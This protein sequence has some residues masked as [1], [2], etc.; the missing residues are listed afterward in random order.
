MDSLFHCPIEEKAET[1]LLELCCMKVD[2][3]VD[4]NNSG[5]DESWDLVTIIYCMIKAYQLKVNY[6]S[7]KFISTLQ[8][9][10]AQ[11]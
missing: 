6:L 3:E 8:T 2:N 5:S 1:N 9:H 11:L 10:A 4:S 7:Q